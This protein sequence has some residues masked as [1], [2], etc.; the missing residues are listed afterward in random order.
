MNEGWASYW[1]YKTLNQ[2]DLSPSLHL[3]FIKRH[4]DVITP[5]VGM[6]N[7]YYLGFKM[8]QDLEKRYGMDKIFEVRALERDESF[9]RR[10]LTEELC[11]EMNLFQYAEKG[12]NYVVE[13]IS[14]HS[15]WTKIRSTLCSTCGINMIPNIVVDDISK[16]DNTLVLR[17]I[18]EG[19]E[20][21]STYMEA[22]LKHIFDLWKYPVELNT[23]I[24]KNKTKVC[25][26]ESKKISYTTLR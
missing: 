18:Y 2:L 26:E 11:N 1:H 22:T 8:F 5:L 20:L 6:I 7:P 17:H 15:G 10:Y 21:N 23:V 4:N 9:I 24:D 3:E 13:E 19:R 14:D 16:K 12:S 25:C